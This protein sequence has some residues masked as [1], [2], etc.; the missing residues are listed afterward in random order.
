MAL[1]EDLDVIA[2]DARTRKTPCNTLKRPHLLYTPLL[3]PRAFPPSEE[4][5]DPNKARPPDLEK[6][7]IALSTHAAN[8][9]RVKERTAV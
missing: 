5:G 1:I 4:A 2:P 3:T 6:R 9:R 8:L 7:P